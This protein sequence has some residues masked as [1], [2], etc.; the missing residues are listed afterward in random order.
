[1]PV[2][3]EIFRQ[4]N[5]PDASIIERFREIPTADLIDVMFKR[6]A[7]DCAIRPVYLPIPKIV[8]PAITV[9]APDAAFEVVKMGLEM[10]QP[11]DVVMINARG[12]VDHA[13]LG[14]NVCRGLKARGLAA[15]M[16]DGAI[17]DVSE[18]REEGFPVFSRGVALKMGP[19]VGAGEVNVPIAFGGIVINPGDIIVADEDGIVAVPPHAA[20]EVLAAA[21]RL[22]EGHMAAQPALLRG[23]VT[24]IA[25][26]LERAEQNGAVFHDGS[27]QSGSTNGSGQ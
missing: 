3:F 20:E 6:G 8:G 24:R 11:G 10:S 19:I 25:P 26:I 18:I 9:S 27:Y 17:R 1:M 4:I 16:A 2:G 15:L 7:V 5:R 22:H 13:L 14:G 21:H 12:N 23:E